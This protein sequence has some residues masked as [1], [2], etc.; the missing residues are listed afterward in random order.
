MIAQQRISHAINRLLVLA[1]A[2]IAGFVPLGAVQAGGLIVNEASNGPSGAKEFYEFVV[3][4]SAGDPTG[5]VNLDGWILDDNNG[6]WEG[7]TSGVGISP[8]YARFDAS[9]SFVCSALAAMPPGSIIVVYNDGDP[10]PNL[11]PDDATDANGD[12]V[13]VF[14]ARGAC[15]KTC[16]GPPDSTDPSYSSCVT[17]ATPSY[18]PIALRN[19][20]D[21][22][23]SRDAGG[24]LFHG[25]TYGDIT[26]PYPSGSFSISSSSGSESTFVFSCGDWYSSGNFSRLSAKLETPGAA[27]DAANQIF[28][29]N[30]RLGN[31]DYANPSAKANC[32]LL[33]D[34]QVQ[35]SSTVSTDPVNGAAN[36][37]AIP[38]AV[39]SYCL[40]VSNT[41]SA[42]AE[43]LIT[44]D[45]IPAS[46][47]YAAGTMFSGTDCDTAIDPEDDDNSGSDESDPWGAS[48]SGATIT[49]IAKTLGPSESFAL[50]FDATVN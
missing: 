38:G 20:G 31:F 34:L 1:A 17:A 7:S 42:S 6:E 26:T 46:M 12:G 28:L 29:E 16:S 44:T 23:Q 14:Q 48:I 33:P 35:K 43:S 10:N 37:K 47:T 4:G 32:V 9:S 13:Y 19:S 49:M 39:V 36:P 41:G 5:S 45:N 27:N 8:G 25:F 22:A 15:I 18:T 24:T 50:I 21:V 30:V 3:V 40:L 11:P 2:L